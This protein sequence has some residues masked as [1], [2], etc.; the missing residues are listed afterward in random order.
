MDIDDFSN[1]F[2]KLREK[3]LEQK[4]WELWLAKIPNMTQESYMSYD[5]MLNIAKQRETKHDIPINGIY[6]DQAFF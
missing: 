3:E 6:I 1:Q 4:V 2:L 5:E